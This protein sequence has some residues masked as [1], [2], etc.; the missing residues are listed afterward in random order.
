M[1]PGHA[2]L[3][4]MPAPSSAAPVTTHGVPSTSALKSHPATSTLRFSFGDVFMSASTRVEDAAAIRNTC[5]IRLFV[6][7][8]CARMTSARYTPDLVSAV[9][10]TRPTRSTRNARRPTCWLRSM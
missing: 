8:N 10:K 6:N 1:V 4:V 5:S 2:P 7:V 9:P 3:M